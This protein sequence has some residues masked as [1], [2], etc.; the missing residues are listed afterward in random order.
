MVTRTGDR[1]LNP[2]LLFIT[3]L[4]TALMLAAT[5]RGLTLETDI[6]ASL[7]T[8]NR[9][10]SD[11]LF[12]FDNHPIQDRVL[13]SVSL[14]T[15]DP[16]RLVDCATLVE[17][18]LKA[19]G[20]FSS[21]GMDQYQTMMPEL[22]ELVAENLPVLFTQT[23]LETMITPQL[24][25]SKVRET[26]THTRDRLLNLDEIGTARFIA[27]DPL[28]FK[29]L[30][31]ARLKSLTPV[32]DFRIHRGKL[33]SG[34]SRH[35]LIMATPQGSGTD[36]KFSARAVSLIPDIQTQA[37]KTFAQPG[38][39]LSLTSAGAFKAA[40]D[41][42]TIVKADV[43]KAVLIATAAIAL[44]LLLAFP[45]P[46]V[47]LLAL[48]PALFG[49]IAGL[50][51]YSLL[52]DSISLMVLGFGGAIISITVDHGIA[53]LLFLDRPYKAYGKQASVEVK[54]V[55]LVVTLT[56]VCAFS[57]L[58]LSDFKILEELGKFTALGMGF[59]FIFIHTVFPKIVPMLQPARPR[60]LPL[61]RAVNALII[62]GDGGAWLA[63]ALVS[64]LVWFAWPT[65]NADLSTMN[66]V[67]RETRADDTRFKKIWGQGFSGKSHLMMV[68]DNISGLQDLSDG[69]AGQVTESENT[70]AAASGVILAMI[71]PGE[72]QK[73]KNHG[74]WTRFWTDEKVG[75]LG[76]TLA[77]EGQKLGFTP[78]AFDPFIQAL[79]S[80][81]LTPGPVAIP[82]SL[83]P[84]MGL[85]PSADGTKWIRTAGLIRN[86]AMDARSFFETFSPAA[87]VF[88]PELFSST[89]GSILFSTFI[90]MFIIIGAAVGLLLLIFFLDLKLAAF[91]M[92]P[93][94]FAFISTLGTMKLIGHD[95]DIPSLMLSIIIFGMG[96]DYSLFFIRSY[97]RYRDESHP[98]LALIRLAVF[99]A[100]IS[101][102]IGFGVM[103]LAEHSLLRSAGLTSLLGIGY[104]L[105]GTF[106]ILPPLLRRHLLSRTG[107]SVPG[108]TPVL[109]PGPNPGFSPGT[110]PG[111]DLISDPVHEHGFGPV[112]ERVEPGHTAR[113]LSRYST[114]EA[115]PRMFARF[116][117]KFD[118]M[119]RELPGF[120]PEKRS[121]TRILDIGSGFGVPACF[122]LEFFPHARIFGIEPDPETRRISSMAVS[123]QGSIALG[124]APNLPEVSGAVHIAMMLDMSHFLTLRQFKNTLE[125]IKAVMAPDG[126]LIVRA[127]IPP[128]GSPSPVWRFEALKLK[129]NGVVP[130]YLSVETI[131]DHISKAGFKVKLT[132][133]SGNN[134]E[135]AWFVAEVSQ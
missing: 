123:G 10:I 50:F 130:H 13:I 128:E 83:Y 19:S 133:P 91:A 65:F 46:W 105:M 62:K 131:T 16:D 58:V 107:K 48:V 73:T 32:Q 6:V 84:M 135:T 78:K 116:K 68:A 94:G 43:Q 66:T 54:A 134:P 75:S 11:A 99:M 9:V 47:G 51:V 57:A 18:R 34:D 81:D 30:V 82:E 97:Q 93:V 63:L 39:S 72:K 96:I 110:D 31:L 106:L 4:I 61:K 88:E 122:L 70:D 92:L 12:F 125:R 126:C 52:Y 74:A 2:L 71:F 108:Q 45:R 20:L 8:K 67:S 7:P 118:P 102:L 21:V 119:F 109:V 40:Y 113:I 36:S 49:A 114:A 35:C 59:S 80:F 101:T 33:L 60:G 27:S 124:R 53:Y 15:D 38:E 85:S 37:K 79:T 98:S 112:R 3:I 1:S 86:P 55:G 111:P 95:L 117:L 23:Q 14:G 77:N 29:N 22:M 5:L 129:L 121:V 127:I 115:Y 87:T 41:N 132:Q 25:P 104:C 26:L 76:R 103:G 56:T 44:L 24:T 100:G 17:E 69:L 90:K 89:L 120:L 64:I 42:E 28:G